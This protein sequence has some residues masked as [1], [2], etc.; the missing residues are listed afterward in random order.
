MTPPGSWA[1]EVMAPST[2]GIFLRAFSF[3]HVRQLE[4]VMGKV[5][6]RAW[7][8]GAGPGDARLVIDV[9]STICEVEGKQKQG[10]A[11]G[12]TKVL[13]YHP[14]LASRAD[15]GEI[16]HARMRKGSA[17]TSRG[18][19]RFIDE[20]VARLRRA[21]AAGEIVMR[22]DSGFWSGDTL[23]VLARHRV[24]YTMAV[25]TNTKG[26]A[27][28]IAAIDEDSWVDIDYTADGQA[29]VAETV[30]GGRR[31]IVRR[32]RLTEPATGQ[33]VAGLAA[34]RVSHRPGRHRRRG[35]RLPPSARQRRAGH[36]RPQRRLRAGTL[37]LRQLLRQLRLAAMRGA[38]PQP[39][40]LDRHHRRTR[41]KRSPSPAP[42]EPASSPCPP[43]S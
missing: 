24:R 9:D 1:I 29:Q 12:Y 33:A 5:L 37:P 28:A 31:L 38:G 35:R 34:L 20:V 19:R 8:L 6:A 30:Y 36:P 16:V 42:C 21:G 14:I 40:P 25:R 39:H 41:S 22:F 43:A 4:A 17:N 15:T 2:L 27:E 32:T 13:G 11:Y 26:V 7:E 18:A 10:A 23:K 3:G